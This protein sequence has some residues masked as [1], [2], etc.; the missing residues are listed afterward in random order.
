MQT[1]TTKYHGATNT[2]GSRVSATSESGIRIYIAYDDAL[3]SEDAHRV[4]AQALSDKLGWGYRMVCGATK[5]GYVFVP[6]TQSEIRSLYAEL[7]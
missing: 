5:G 4:A 2:R 7:P 3:S 6:L 1:I